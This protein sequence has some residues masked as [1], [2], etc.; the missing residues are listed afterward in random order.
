MAA[1]WRAMDDATK[2][3]FIAE[4]EEHKKRYEVEK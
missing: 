3:P 2:A 1:E 4:T